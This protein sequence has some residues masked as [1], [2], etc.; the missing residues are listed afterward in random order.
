L[1][2]LA[3]LSTAPPSARAA[4]GHSF[5]SF[6]GE[7]SG[8]G[9][10][11]EPDG[12]AAVSSSGEV[13]VAD[14]GNSRIQ[15]FTAGGEY[16]SQFDGLTAPNPLSAPTALAVDDAPVS[17]AD[18][19][20]GDVYVVNA[21]KD[22][23]SKF[24]G[25][26][27]FVGEIHK[28]AEGEFG[29]LDGVAVDANG[30]V[31]VYQASGEIDTYSNGVDNALLTGRFSPQATGPGF[32]VDA[33][34]DL[35]AVTSEHK[36][37]KLTGA[38]ESLIASV[39]GSES[40]TAV[41]VDPSTN[42]AYIDEGV[43]VGAFSPAGG[44]LERFGSPQLEGGNGLT[45][46]PATGAVYV[47][48]DVT[49]QIDVFTPEPPSLPAVAPGSVYA[50]NVTA[51]TAELRTS[52]S[53]HGASTT[54]YFQYGSADCAASP[55]SC[56]SVPLPPGT[57]IGSGFEDQPEHIAL[58]GL[59]PGTSYQYRVL[60]TNSFG[61]V[62]GRSVSGTF[63]TARVDGSFALSDGRVW[64]L[65]SPADL[66]GAAIEPPAEGAIQASAD[67]TAVSYLA[68]GAIEGGAASNAML[69]QVLSKRVG[70]RWSS[71]DIATP[72]ESETGENVG[73]GGEY[74]L[75]SEDL[76]LG[77]VQPFGHTPLSP[78]ASEQTIYIR[79]N[80]T[81]VYEPLVAPAD[82]PPGTAFGGE[83]GG[84]FFQ[85]AT[86]DLAH[87]VFTSIVPL[88]EGAEERSLYEWT[89]GVIKPVSL[90]KEHSEYARLPL[91]GYEGTDVTH[92][93]SADGAR[94]V[95]SPLGGHL[96]VRDTATEQTVQLDTV[97][98]G[99]SGEGEN[100][101]VFEAASNDG[102][103]VFFL[104]ERQLVSGSQAGFRSPDLYECEMIEAAGK[105]DCD[106]KDLTVAGES[107]GVQGLLG[108][109]E[110]ASSLYLVAR[111]VLAN[112]T[113]TAGE[114]AQPEADNLYALQETEGSWSTRFIAGLAPQDVADWTGQL[115]KHTA[116]TSPDGRYVAFMS[117]RE[118]TGFDNHDVKSGEPDEEVFLY[119]LASGRLICTSC[120]PS[121]ARPSGILDTEE[122][123]PVVDRFG[124]WRGRWLAAN[125]PTF[126]AADIAHA[127]H[128]PRYVFDDGRVLFNSADALV[129]HDTNS[130]MDVYEYEPP[131]AGGARGCTAT[132]EGFDEQAAGCV[133]LVS[134]GTS[135]R[136]SVLLD[137]SEEA[138]D[139]F[140]LTPQALTPEDTA[141]E[142]YE[143]YDAHE[144]PE[145]TVC[146]VQ[147]PT[148]E[149]IPCTSS[150]R[151]RPEAAVPPML[152]SLPATAG[153]GGSGN[154]LTP[155][156]P[157]ARHTPLSRSQ[158]L[159]RA[160]EACRHKRKEQR[161]KCKAAAER[162]YGAHRSRR[163]HR[164]P[165]R[166]GTR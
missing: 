45:V 114:T 122:P 43:T 64:E 160:I 162:R 163:P 131:Q 81:G 101:A 100:E 111:G 28:G 89:G 150:E 115:P 22:V 136:E 26:G 159:A 2:T 60:A 113:N 151:C 158:L 143:V 36:V 12:I 109:N 38:G 27:E 63:T 74:R 77:L 72:H 70:G 31:W 40:A 47:S 65:V 123:R 78:E 139:V 57:P 133:S 44:L 61:T 18:P 52:I 3:L 153:F 30:V 53:P 48:N 149:A 35:Y 66:H 49:D 116:E 108:T 15:R 121:G 37:A 132:S 13:Y 1:A 92:A 90:L 110:N 79:N 155:A 42:D 56:T 96:Y 134:S 119:D 129:P 29:G 98:P 86:S 127:Y 51:T 50:A 105:L 23:I 8:N 126:A 59:Q 138:T 58:V 68:D 148:I 154:I 39:D 82:A 87:V 94:V 164:T 144:C 95:W 97:Q 80:A 140:F 10:F 165:R 73:A 4:R 83:G 19:S 99:A 130:K 32:A 84:V 34:D 55:S 103:K 125:L 46:S 102:S 112:N 120:N 157:S 67:G 145:G 6:G 146:T 128:Q 124:V 166:R 7:G 156:A 16:I 141:G 25:A 91:L 107:A 142:Q 104:E 137:A 161:A 21:G 11:K 152:A 106:L 93:I 135:P 54:F 88:I 76:S 20:R 117:E 24:T 118:L 33:Q 75:F 85:G 71:Q 9:L 147:P 69:S 62:E 14:K 5:S 41:A 17:V